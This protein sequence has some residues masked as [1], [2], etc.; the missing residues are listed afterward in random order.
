VLRSIF[1]AAPDNAVTGLE[2]ALR[3]EASRGGA[4]AA[5]HDLVAREAAE[6]RVRGAVFQPVARL[7]AHPSGKAIRFPPAV[8]ALL[9]S[10][11]RMAEPELSETAEILSAAKKEDP[12]AAETYDRLCQAAAAG[13]RLEAPEFLVA[14]DCLNRDQPGGAGLFAHFLDLAPLARITLARLPEWVAR[15]TDE[16]AAAARLAYKDACALSDDAGP[17]FFEVLYANLSEPWLILRVLS[18]VMDHPGDSYVAVSELARF[19]V[20]VL[21]DID[22]RLEGIAKFDPTQGLAAGAAAAD[23]VHVAAM[24][25]AE[26]ESALELSK[27]GPW[28]RRLG[29]QKKR[30]AVSAE[31][32]LA[33]VEKV[34]DAALPLQ[35]VRFGKGV[36]GQP[37]LTA[38]P[39]ADAIRKAEGMLAFVQH[40]RNGANQAGYGAARAKV[41]EQIEGRIDQY[42]EDLLE[43]L[44]AEEVENPERVRAFL[45]ITAQMIDIIRD[46][47]AGQIVRRRA[48]AA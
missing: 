12:S 36:R 15:M 40:S 31:S 45:E 21:D 2:F 34:L 19:G 39:D 41:L 17:R 5:V 16:R 37:R 29:L 28:G 23:Q 20:Y 26:F 22:A 38:D 6:R 48:A 43:M 35:V 44:R 10:A 9:W 3:S 46:S 32:R 30:L 33:Q 1:G 8:V 18:A 27:E 11:V 4:M 7:C 42:V 24:E 14:I 25:V 47:K 13:L